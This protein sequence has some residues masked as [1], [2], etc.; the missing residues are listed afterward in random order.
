MA[1]LAVTTVVA[2]L[3]RNAREALEHV[4]LA[5]SMEKKW[6]VQVLVVR[7]AILGNRV[8]DAAVGS[9]VAMELGHKA[10]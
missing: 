3:A 5:I 6:A 1:K 9:A 2:K 10:T 4:A 7:E 8:G